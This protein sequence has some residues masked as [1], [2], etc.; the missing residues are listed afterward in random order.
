MSSQP[1]RIS[2]FTSRDQLPSR[3]PSNRPPSIPA[4]TWKEQLLYWMF[5]GERGFLASFTFP[6][7]RYTDAPTEFQFEKIFRCKLVPRTQQQRSA[8][9]NLSK[10]L[11]MALVFNQ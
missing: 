8:R 9:N 3:H 1:V 6:P 4:Y 10:H 11:P 2:S 7:P 5:V